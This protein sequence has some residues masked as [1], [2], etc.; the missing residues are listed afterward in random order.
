MIG[1][2]TIDIPVSMVGIAADIPAVRLE[3]DLSAEDVGLWGAPGNA[4]LAG[5]SL[6]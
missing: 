6:V 3:T 2:T 5:R 4:G 1:D